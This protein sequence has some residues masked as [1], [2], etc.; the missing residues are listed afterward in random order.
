MAF[1]KWQKTPSK[2]GLERSWLEN[3]MK[4]IGWCLNNNI[5]ISVSPDWRDE[6]QRWKIDINI[7]GK[8]HVDPKR[9]DDDVLDKLLEYYKYYYYKQNTNNNG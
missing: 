8:L 2:K 5:K 7:N 1:K 9:Y 6:L 3:E 4:I